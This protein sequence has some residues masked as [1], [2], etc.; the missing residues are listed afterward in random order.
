MHP[1][2]VLPFLPCPPHPLGVVYVP[3]RRPRGRSMGV[4]WRGDNHN[5]MGGRLCGG[6]T[7]TPPYPLGISSR[8]TPRWGGN[9]LSP[10][11]VREYAR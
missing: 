11:L 6:G 3:Q 8:G 9:Y 5:G 2:R 7:N 4:R 10:L 1:R